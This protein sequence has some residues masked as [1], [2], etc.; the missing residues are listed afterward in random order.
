MAEVLT[1]AEIEARY[2]NEWILVEDPYTNEALEVQ[3]GKV[4]WHSP[5]RD[6]M[7]RK[8]IEF[9]LPYSAYLYTGK[10]PENT[11]IIL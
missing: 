9:R 6:E 4:R 5:D 1:I 10:I 8:A 11:A 2:P 7:Y 3:S